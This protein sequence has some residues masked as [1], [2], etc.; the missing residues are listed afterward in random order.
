MKLLKN[1]PSLFNKLFFGYLVLLVIMIWPCVVSIY[2]LSELENFATSIAKHD[3][4]LSKTIE[5][6]KAIPPSME[7]EGRRLVT[8]YKEDAYQSLMSLIQDFK[9]NLI[10]VYRDDSK[11]IVSIVHNIELNLDKLEKL[12]SIAN[13][14]LPKSSPPEI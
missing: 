12:A 3:L 4:E 8:L 9:D 13:A 2:N 5:Q 7:A 10:S 6:L 14:S 11:E 1:S